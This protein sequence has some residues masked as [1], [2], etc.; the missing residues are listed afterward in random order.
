M[1]CP[2]CGIENLEDSKFCRKCATPLPSS[3]DIPDSRTETASTPIKEL[4]TGSTFAGRYQIIEELGHGAAGKV[5]KVYD[6]KIKE[7]IALKLIKPEI[8]S[9]R[10]TLERFGNELRLARKVAQRNICKMYDLGEAEGAHHF[11]Q[12]KGIVPKIS[13]TKWASPCSAPYSG[14][15]EITC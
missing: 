5:Y 13:S 15:A 3:K 14:G 11:E 4:T 2:S 10:E 9:D 7:K 6:T 8:A 1:K 12:E